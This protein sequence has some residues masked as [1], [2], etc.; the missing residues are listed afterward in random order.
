[1]CPLKGGW[2]PHPSQIGTFVGMAFHLLS[3]GLP[4]LDPSGQYHPFFRQSFV[5]FSK[6]GRVTLP[7]LLLSESCLLFFPKY[8]WPK[9]PPPGIQSVEVSNPPARC[10]RA[11]SYLLHENVPRER[12]FFAE[13]QGGY[14][15]S[16]PCFAPAEGLT[17]VFSH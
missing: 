7:F 4:C 1:M 17:D 11:F 3:L 2:M 16:P 10:S 6:L 5:F 8:G 15:I 13:K 12:L 14:R 9:S